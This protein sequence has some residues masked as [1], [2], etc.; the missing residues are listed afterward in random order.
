[1]IRRALLFLLLGAASVAL[2][3]SPRMFR[4]WLALAGSRSGSGGAAAESHWYD[5]YIPGSLAIWPMTETGGVAVAD[6]SGNGN[7]GAASNA[8]TAGGTGRTGRGTR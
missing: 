1:M 3:Q 8:P 6:V 2:A 7:H 4:D 5:S